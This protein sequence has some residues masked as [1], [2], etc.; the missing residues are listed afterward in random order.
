MIADPEYPPPAPAAVEGV[1]PWRT[2]HGACLIAP[3]GVRARTPTVTCA[4]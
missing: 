2:D 4:S 3:R 1:Q